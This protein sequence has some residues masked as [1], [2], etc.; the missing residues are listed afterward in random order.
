MM[1]HCHGTF[2]ASKMFAK[3]QIKLSINYLTRVV[4]PLDVILMQYLRINYLISP[5]VF[6]HTFFNVLN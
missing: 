6:M 5:A 4:G 1:G 2:S 3:L